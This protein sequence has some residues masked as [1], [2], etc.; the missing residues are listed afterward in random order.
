MIDSDE[1]TPPVSADGDT[2]FDLDAPPS[3]S[4]SLELMRR[5]AMGDHS[6]AAP[7][8]KDLT[9]Q[10]LGP[11]IGGHPGRFELL[12][13]LGGGGFGT[14][15]RAA[16]QALHSHVA[17]KVLS[18]HSA[19][20]LFLFKQE[21]R[22]LAE[23][24]HEHLIRLHELHQSSDLWFFTME[25]VDGVG[26]DRFVRPGGALDAQSLRDALRQLLRALHHLHAAGRV[27]R[28]V[29]PQNVLV[30]PHGRLVLL[31]FGL[32]VAAEAVGKGLV[33]GHG[34]GT[35][36]FLAPE[37]LTGAPLGPAAD[38]W[39]VGVMLI[40]AL[41][42]RAVPIAPAVPAVPTAPAGPDAFDPDALAPELAATLADVA[43]VPALADLADLAAALLAYD[44]ASR[45]TAA[46][47]LASLGRRA[48]ALGFGAA[49]RQTV[50]TL[51]RDAEL[52]RLQTAWAAR[53]DGRARFVLVEGRSGV[54]KSALVDLFAATLKSREGPAPWV[55]RGRCHA[56]EAVP[57]K[58]VDGLVDELASLIATLPPAA[59]AAARPVEVAALVHL[60]PVLG[61]AFPGVS[62]LSAAV[63]DPR[64]L[65]TRGLRALLDHVAAERPVALVIDDLQWG[66]ADGA[67]VL[68]ALLT[69]P[70]PARAPGLFLV[71]TARPA[72][73]G[74]FNADQATWQDRFLSLVGRRRSRVAVE[75]IKLG[76]LTNEAATH[77][78]LALL[79]ADG[80]RADVT[81][82]DL[83]ATA[84][85]GVPL[86]IRELVRWSRSGASHDDVPS[87]ELM[88]DRRCGAL[89]P[90]A[91]RLLSVV[92]LAGRPVARRAAALAAEVDDEPAALA[93]LAR[94]H[95]AHADD[96]GERARLTP[97][98]DRVRQ[99]ALARLPT[100][101][102]RD[103]F[104]RLAPAAEAEGGVDPAVLAAWYRGAGDEARELACSITAGL[105][106]ADLRSLEHA[107]TLL[108]RALEL[109]PPG[110]PRTSTVAARLGA[111]HGLAGHPR[112]GAAAYALA[113]SHLEGDEARELA[114]LGFDLIG[115]SG[116]VERAQPLASA[117]LAQLGVRAPRTAPGALWGWLMA[118]RR[119]RRRGLSLEPRPV[120]PR[121]R[122]VLD[123]RLTAGFLWSQTHFLR[124][125]CVLTDGL[126]DA[127][128]SGDAE[129]AASFLCVELGLAAMRAMEAR[130]PW[131]D[132]VLA[133]L[134]PLVDAFPEVRG[135]YETAL[136]M[137][138][139]L[140]GDFER[141]ADFAQRAEAS[142]ATR[143]DAGIDVHLAR[144]FGLEALYL[145]GRWRLLADRLG[146]VEAAYATHSSGFF[147]G[148]V[149]LQT[150]WMADLIADRPDLGR[151]RVARGSNVVYESDRTAHIG[152]LIALTEL[153]LYESNGRGPLARAALDET[154]G[155]L[156]RS[157][158][159]RIF[160]LVRLQ[161]ETVR[162]RVAMADGDTRA[163]V[164]A[165]RRLARSKTRLG[166]AWAPVAS[167]F[168]ARSPAA[169]EAALTDAEARLRR[170]W[171]A[172]AR[173]RSALAA[174]APA[175]RRARSC[176][177]RERGGRHRRRGVAPARAR[178]VTAVARRLARV[179]VTLRRASEWPFW[180]FGSGSMTASWARM[181]PSRTGSGRAPPGGQVVAGVRWSDPCG[182]SF[183]WSWWR[184]G[185]GTRP[186]RHVMR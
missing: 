89:S 127:L 29:K 115:Q 7:E 108:Q 142:L 5:V 155:P 146:A 164:R 33:P 65:A 150:G 145:S 113:A 49:G 16:D 9:G 76:P 31:D 166:A 1:K 153:A 104:T 78:A 63:T 97:V 6:R 102:R 156:M 128:E 32:A 23:L 48:T 69:S 46:A 11:P 172:A 133:A 120:D 158:L 43:D 110:D 79:T 73:E 131:E 60:F 38:L 42:G 152:R 176:T 98:H 138:G 159:T 53:A 118:R 56:G 77:L 163:A 169:V 175:G 14:V 99:A 13:R 12:S 55:V 125:W 141:A 185:V 116:D 74:P 174:R 25:L 83:I 66:D 36:R 15:Y 122:L 154:W 62:G 168:S 92:A 160:P 178:R 18:G 50:G 91:L 28:D 143:H 173:G 183:C 170:A 57:F 129:R 136:A 177:G 10:W 59:R 90:P 67:A 179:D 162:L 70:P 75:T 165:G 17:L 8:A 47:A 35:R 80:G 161:V 51:G 44:P 40:D 180:T 37:N 137:N 105:R 124:S 2:S 126:Y 68:T 34:A 87:L 61:A 114:R 21:F 3:D 86:F 132:T 140:H 109:L 167:A 20:D 22:G 117:L 119:V 84:S 107:A 94:A 103:L 135:R 45:P 82:A 19:R 41:A 52:A 85:G 58:L 81:H 96:V 30:E 149:D 151:A 4:P 184:R 106:A 139:F 95:L 39:A 72:D 186:T 24:R 64:E 100:E 54:G 111:V 26:F 147:A 93:E 144:I 88:L 148:I 171:H 121:R 101:V 130:S 181:S 123:A 157:G 182:V 112:E 71:A 134:K 27:H